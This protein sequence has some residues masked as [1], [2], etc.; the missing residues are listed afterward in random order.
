MAL[1]EATTA[2]EQ[3]GV[4]NAV[5]NAE[6]MMADLIECTRPALPLHWEETLESA[7]I[8]RW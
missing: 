5:A 6:W 8:Q 1:Q 7:Q 2:L 3:V 4:E